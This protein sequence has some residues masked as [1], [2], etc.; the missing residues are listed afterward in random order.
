MDPRFKRNVASNVKSLKIIVTLLIHDGDLKTFFSST[1]T[2]KLISE[3]SF[4]ANAQLLQEQEIDL[5]SVPR[6][7]NVTS[8]ISFRL[9]AH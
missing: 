8:T 6:S 4:K 1:F 7:P 2:E 9:L 3:V 5:A